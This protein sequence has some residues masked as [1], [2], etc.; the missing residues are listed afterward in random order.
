MSPDNSSKRMLFISPKF[1]GYEADIQ[2]AF[3]KLG[4]VVDFIDER[5]HNSALARA[6]V[7]VFPKLI[8]GRIERYYREQRVRIRN[9]VYD[10]VFLLKGEVI[11]EWFLKEIW[12]ANPNAK[13]IFYTYDSLSNSPSSLRHLDSFH[14]CWT[15]DY[16]DAVSDHRMQVLPLFYTEEFYPQEDEP[17]THDISF[18]GTVHSGR[19]NAIKTLFLPFPR[20]F[21][22]FY[23][24]ALWYFVLSKYIL[25]GD[26]RYVRYQDI[27]FT[28]LTR[29]EVAGIFRGSV[30]VADIQRQGQTGLTMRTFEVLASGA[31]LITTND[32]AKRL[33]PEISKKVLVLN[34]FASADSQRKAK[35]FIE[36][37]RSDTTSPVGMS[38]YSINRWAE[39]LLNSP[40]VSI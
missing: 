15:I 36:K 21:E 26:F 39:T 12:I 16:E 18:V 25:R 17:R 37:A 38:K 2:A 8:G 31:S 33:E 10:Y 11:P 3:E 5:P 1:F 23:C 6:L 32:F 20:V 14:V 24:P 19:Y 13:R 22:F 28:K 29:R 34:E 27:S 9:R 35:M 40:G 30:A 4:L 7:R